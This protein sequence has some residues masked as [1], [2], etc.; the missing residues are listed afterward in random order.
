MPE[1]TD[2]RI[3][4][5][6]AVPIT[7]VLGAHRSE[8]RRTGAELVGPCPKCGGEDRFGIHLQKNVFNC[9]RCERGGDAIEFIKFHKNLDFAA[10]VDFLAPL[11]KPVKALKNGADGRRLVSRSGPWKYCDPASGDVRYTRTRLNFSDGSKDVVFDGPRNGPPLLYGGERLADLGE[12]QRIWIVEGEAKVDRLFEFGEIAV[13]GDCGATASKWLPCHAELL[14]G[15]DII[16]WP[17]SDW[18]GETYIAN[19]AKCLEGTVASLRVV[20]PFGKPNGAKGR[21]VCDWEGDAE[22][23]AKLAENAE[24]YASLPPDMGLREEATNSA[25]KEP[26]PPAPNREELL[27]AHWIRRELPPRDHLLGALVCTTSRILMFGPTGIGK[28]ITGMMAG[29]AMAS[30]QNFLNWVGQRT[31]RVMYLDGEMPQETF[32]ERMRMVTAR[33]GEGIPFY[34]YNW[35]ALGPDGIPPLN[36]PIGQAWL[37]REI[38]AVLPDIVF[39]DNIMSLLLGS[40]AE[41]ESWA[42][43]R[44]FIRE[45]TSRRIAQ[46]WLGHANDAGKSFGTKTREWEMDA[47][48]ALS[49]LDGASDEPADSFAFQLEFRKARLRTPQNAAQFAPLI[50]RPGADWEVT[51]TRPSSKTKAHGGLDRLEYLNAYDRL[52]DGIV[53]SPGFDGKPVRKVKSDAI[54]D[55]LK[56]RGFLLLDEKGHVAPYGRKQLHNDQGRTAQKPAVGGK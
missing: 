24:P 28:T 47:V 48:I 17:D 37:R 20:R 12:R 21:D 55:E 4:Q 56:S 32:Q 19:A 29:G 52:A 23:L 7:S 16:F 44:G 36:T 38:E 53:E 51:P 41:E 39:F 30:A 26:L 34:G 10:A 46:W 13:S 40:M 9:R 27:A 5:A 50:V 42:P 43:M 15:L 3:E 22:A 35:E 54:R 45:L 2:Q 6:R 49:T 1:L 11:D 14:R 18:P 33:Y 8:L 31:A 25:S